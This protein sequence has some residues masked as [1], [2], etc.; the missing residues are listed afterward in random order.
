MLSLMKDGGFSMWAVLLFGGTTF[1]TAALFA[2]KGQLRK[3]AGIRAMTWSTVF[4][5]L[6]GI[7]S[8]FIAVMFHVTGN[9]D[10]YRDP[11]MPRMV[12]RGLGESIVPAV[13]GF[14][15][16]SLAWLLVAVGTRRSQDPQDPID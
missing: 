13:L 1:A 2:L 11:E 10:W 5:I 3:L 6:S 7:A 9:D 8:N 12:M 4:S 14:S 16:L 15:L